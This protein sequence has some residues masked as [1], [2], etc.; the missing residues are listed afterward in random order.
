M[1][2]VQQQA[3]VGAPLSS[4]WK[5]VADPRRYPDWFP[6]VVE[7]EG[8]RFEE[9]AEFVQVCRQPLQGRSEAHFLIDEINELRELRMHCTT[10]GMFVHWQ[11]T[12]AGGGTF[13]SAE[14][15]M[16]PLR[17]VDKLFDA[18]MGARFFRRWLDE[19]IDGLKQAAAG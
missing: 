5:L 6:R 16:S 15:G 14:F 8:Q 11:L 2:A 18:V 17:R 4:V 13:L 1:S 10:S 9:G 19:A 7:V 12:D 3:L